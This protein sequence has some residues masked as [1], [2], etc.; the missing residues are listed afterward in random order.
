VILGS[1]RESI[2]RGMELLLANSCPV[3]SIENMTAYEVS[4]Q[5]AQRQDIAT[6][7]EDVP[8]YGGMQPD[9]SRIT[10]FTIFREVEDK[11]KSRQYEQHEIEAQSDTFEDYIIYDQFVFD[12]LNKPPALAVSNAMFD[13]LRELVIAN[14]SKMLWIAGSYERQYPSKMS[15]VASSVV[16]LLAQSEPLILSYFCALPDDPPED[17]SKEEAGILSMVYSLL[18]QL[19]L[20]LQSSFETSKDLSETRFKSLDGTMETWTEALELLKDLGSISS[21]YIICVIDGVGQ[22]DYGAGESAL[23]DF[24]D[25]VHDLMAGEN[26]EQEQDSSHVFK[27]LFTTAGRS[28]TLCRRLENEEM[29][30]EDERRGSLDFGRSAPGMKRISGLEEGPDED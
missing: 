23:A 26:V 14:S 3:A 4:G 5:P 2:N 24:L 8:P 30:F 22:L 11:P 6:A 19:I 12:L 29:L 7:Y 1:V 25:V 21:P 10:A 28:T 13:R 16:S 27:V 9:G 18:R 15:S 17:Q 20:S